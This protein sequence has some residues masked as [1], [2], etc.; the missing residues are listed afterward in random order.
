MMRISPVVCKNSS[1]KS[2]LIPRLF[3]AHA[4]LSNFS[5]II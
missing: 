4:R 1:G 5:K 2:N 3:K